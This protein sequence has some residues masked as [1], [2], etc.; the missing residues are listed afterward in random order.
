MKAKRTASAW[1]KPE[2]RHLFGACDAGTG[3]VAHRAARV[4]RSAIL[5]GLKIT[6]AVLDEGIRHLERPAPA[7]TPPPAPHVEKIDIR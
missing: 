4:A 7:E 2:R 1:V 5:L 6:R 3:E